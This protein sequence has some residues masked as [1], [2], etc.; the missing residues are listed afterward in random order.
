ME[1][2]SWHVV[3]SFGVSWGDIPSVGLCPVFP[4]SP[5]FSSAKWGLVRG[6]PE[7]DML[8][9]L[10]VKLVVGLRVSEAQPEV[11]GSLL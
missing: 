5:L 7:Q 6:T 11:M 1:E 2:E 3:A 8:E 4:L 10:D 9:L